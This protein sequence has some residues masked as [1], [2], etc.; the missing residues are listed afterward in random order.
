MIFL[1]VCPKQL[2]CLEGLMIAAKTEAHHNK[3]AQN[4]DKTHNIMT[5]SPTDLNSYLSII[6]HTQTCQGIS[7]MSVH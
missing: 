6:A 3:S 2:D 4:P 1:D 7:Y 5:E